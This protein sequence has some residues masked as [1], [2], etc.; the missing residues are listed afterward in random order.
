MTVTAQIERIQEQMQ[1][2]RLLRLVE[3]LPALLQE[4]SKKDLAYSDF[5]EDVLSREIA[6]KH[7][8]HTTMKTVMARFP[9]QKTLESFDFKF[10]PSIDPKAIKDLATCRFIADTDNILLLGPPGVGKTHLAV[11]LGLKACAL[12][13][14][15]AFTTAAALIATLMRAHSEG[16]LED[17]LKL[18]VQPKLLIIDEIGYLP[19]DRLGANLF[20][21]LVSRRYE[22]G[23]ILITSNQSLTA[24]GEVF[25]DR[26]I[27]TAILDRLLHHSTIVNI[28]G[29]SYRLKEKRK[30]GLLTRSEPFTDPISRSENGANVTMPEPVLEANR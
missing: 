25:G 26:V 29:E 5:L 8:R 15:T 19:I 16:R 18:L 27:A 1:R 3:E 21:Q 24:W 30:A 23:A 17:K 22:K 28:K 7:E 2:L 10:Q 12:G 14:R 20:F 11:G 13:Y 9:F 6:A 4:A